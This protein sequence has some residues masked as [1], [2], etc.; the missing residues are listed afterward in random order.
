MTHERLSYLLQQFN[1]KRL[2]ETERRELLQFLD[3]LGDNTL[4]EE[5]LRPLLHEQPSHTGD[6]LSTDAIEKVLQSVLAL[7]KFSGQPTAFIPPV[8]R[9]HFLRRW[10]WVAAVIVLVGAGAYLWN[11]QQKEKP[12]VTATSNPVEDLPPGGNRALLT[13]SDGTMIAL[14]SVANGAIAQQGN[15]SIF[16]RASGEIEYTQKGALETEVMMNT[17]KTP[18]GG[19][20][21]LTLPDGTKVWLNSASS[22]TYPAMFVARERKITITG[23]AYLEVA[24]DQSKPFLVDIDGGSSVEVLGTKFNINSYADDGDI[25]TTLVEGSVK[26][27]NGRKEAMLKPG[28]QAVIASSEIRIQQANIEQTLAWKNGKFDFNN[29]PLPTV[30]KQLERWYDIDVQYAGKTPDFEFSGGMN[31]GVKL[32]TIMRFLSDYGV[33]TKLQG[34]TL[35]VSQG[36]SK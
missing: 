5:L 12:S 4:P 1:G 22:I 16:K 33:N 29:V 14:D 27:K 35:I 2:V 18:R 26:V 21:Q 24:K 17:M 32:S 10:G 19:Q 7:D 28:N 15:T 23:E 34:K 31:R 11:T 9:V 3:G 36:G 8:H 25:K 20:Y 6:Y 30:M 13:L